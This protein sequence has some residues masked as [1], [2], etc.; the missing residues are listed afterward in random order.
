MLCCVGLISF[1]YVA[2]CARSKEVAN[3][4][5]EHASAADSSAAANVRVLRLMEDVLWRNPPPTEAV[6]DRIALQVCREILRRM[7][8]GGDTHFDLAAANVLV[9][10]PHGDATDPSNLL[11]LLIDGYRDNIRWMS[12]EL[13]GQLEN[14]SVYAF[15]VFLWE[16]WSRGD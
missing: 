11:V 6:L 16:L 12:P 14:A 1:V 13:M 5:Q 7:E 8:N 4:P 2:R 15:G 3:V 10:Y 9:V